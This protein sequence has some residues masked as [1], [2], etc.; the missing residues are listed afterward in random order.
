MEFTPRPKSQRPKK[1]FWERLVPKEIWGRILIYYMAIPLVSLLLVY[2]LFDRIVMPI[3][4]RHGSEFA[5]PD[6]NDKS[7]E[8]ARKILNEEGLG[9]EVTSREYRPGIPEGVVVSQ[10]PPVG[11]KVKSGRIVKVST[12]IGQKMVRVPAL[13]GFSVRQAQLYIEATGLLL[14]DIAWTFSDS[15]P[16]NVVV[17]AYPATGTE[18]PSGSVVN[19]MV[20]RGRL[21]AGILMPNLIGRQL[22]EAQKMIEEAGL[23]IG[24]VKHVHD[25]N[26]L[27]E[28]VM[29]QSVEASTELQPGEEI[30]LVVS[31]TD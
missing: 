20:N 25:N 5:L 29:E 4:T 30:D 19:L 22:E 15:L 12:S 18:I 9:M 10:Y 7:E 23:K 17:F 21:V 16:E 26:Y 14:G 27:P 8:A 1:P 28:T 24:L 13:A 2:I 3:T 31:T 6:V 11:T